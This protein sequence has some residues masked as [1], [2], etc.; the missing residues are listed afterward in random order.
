MSPCTPCFPAP[1]DS[2]LLTLANP[3]A[4]A[5]RPSPASLVFNNFQNPPSQSPVS[6]PFIF[7]DIQIARPATLFFSQPS[8]LP[9]V[10]HH[11]VLAPS[12]R[13]SI[14]ERTHLFSKPC[15]LFVTAFPLQSFIFGYH[16]ASFK[17]DRRSAA[18]CSVCQAAFAFCPLTLS[19][20]RQ[21][22]P[23]CGHLFGRRFC[24]STLNFRQSTDFRPAGRLWCGRRGRR[25]CP[26]GG[27]PRRNISGKERPTLRSL[28]GF[29]SS[30]R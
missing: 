6:Y 7:S 25:R 18:W 23:P 12:S 20:R 10:C 29:L 28:R 15:A 8:A 11:Q 17:G 4:D 14:S 27:A 3:G 1:L 26:C 13:P 30:G 5:R 19:A 21:L 16:I 22:S 24:F 2:C 9:G